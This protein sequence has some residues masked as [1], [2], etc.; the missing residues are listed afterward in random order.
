MISY[1]LKKKKRLE[2]MKMDHD[3]LTFKNLQ[4]CKHG[5]EIVDD[6]IE[7]MVGLMQVKTKNVENMNGIKKCIMKY[8]QFYLLKIYTNPKVWSNIL[9]FE[10]KIWS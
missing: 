6:T 10:D 2:K 3:L 4:W 8:V 9:L 7:W 5:K 1:S